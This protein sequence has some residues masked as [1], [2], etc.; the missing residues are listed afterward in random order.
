[1]VIC[2]DNHRFQVDQLRSTLQDHETVPGHS[3]NYN[4]HA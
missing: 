2:S 3:L 4:R 1:L